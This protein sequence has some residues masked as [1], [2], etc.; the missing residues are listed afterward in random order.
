MGGTGTVTHALSLLAIPVTYSDAFA[1]NVR[2]ARGLF[3]RRPVDFS[4]VQALLNRIRPRTGTISRKFSSIFFTDAENQW[5]DGLMHSLAATD[6]QSTRSLIFYALVQACLKKRPY[7]LF[8]RA[9]L[10]MRNA[11]V[12]RAFGNATTWEKSFL[13]HMELSLQE[14]CEV[15]QSLV[16]PVRVESERDVLAHSGNFDLIYLDP[17]YFRRNKTTDSYLRRYHFLEGLARY[18]EWD[19]I[20]DTKSPIKEF[21]TEHS[22][23]EWR[24]GSEVLSGLANVAMAYPTSMLAISYVDGEDPSVTQIERLLKKYRKRVTRRS[25]RTSTALSNKSRREVLIIASD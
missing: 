5:L 23:P 21:Q 8:H 15:R 24:C 13:E 19:G 14:A 10:Y 11:Q 20:L 18:S 2:A 6:C 16:A 7:N 9:N 4:E 1:F 25:V 3:D 12:R 17:P 22:P